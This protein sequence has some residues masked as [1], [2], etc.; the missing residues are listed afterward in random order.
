MVWIKL[1]FQYVRTLKIQVLIATRSV[2]D[3]PHAIQVVQ[4]GLPRQLAT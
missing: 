4:L 1:A 2:V 3:P